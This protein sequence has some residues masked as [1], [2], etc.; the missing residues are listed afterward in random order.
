MNDKNRETPLVKMMRPVWKIE[1][2]VYSPLLIHQTK[3]ETEIKLWKTKV[4]LN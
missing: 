3:K 4:I 2:G 1:I